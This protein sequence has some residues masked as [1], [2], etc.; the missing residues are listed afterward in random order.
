MQQERQLF[1]NHIAPTSLESMAFPI[2]R[3]EGTILFDEHNNKFID[4]IGGISVANVGHG[5]PAIVKAV[6]D[7]AAAYMHVMVYGEAVLTPMVQY[8]VQLTSLLPQ[9]LY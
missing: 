5:H 3:A 6:Q 8:G 9:S 1:L 7:Q 2:R 4:L